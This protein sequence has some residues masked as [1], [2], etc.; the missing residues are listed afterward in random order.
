MK[1]AEQETEKRANVTLKKGLKEVCVA[2][3]VNDTFQIVG[4]YI[5]IRTRTVCVRLVKIVHIFR[6]VPNEWLNLAITLNKTQSKLIN[7][8]M[9]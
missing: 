4:K 5:N 8:K 6:L 3:T 9:D 7:S 1:N 2:E